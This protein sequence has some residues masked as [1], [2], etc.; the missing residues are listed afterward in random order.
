M[1]GTSL[2]VYP[3]AGLV[4]LVP[5]TTPRILI[6]KEELEHSF[7]TLH[8]DVTLLGDCQTVL[9]EFCTLLGWQEELQK[10]QANHVRMLESA[11][12]NMY[13]AT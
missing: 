1:S 4:D 2:Q 13:S 12:V 9:H 3:I 11:E 10:L 6:N 8:T 7:G 5:S